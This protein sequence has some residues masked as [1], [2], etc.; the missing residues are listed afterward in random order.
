[1]PVLDLAGRPAD[2]MVAL[3]PDLILMIGAM[4]LLLWAAWRAESQA[5]Q[6][7]VGVACIVLVLVTAG[8]VGY[9]MWR[10]YAAA[11]GPGPIAVDAFR[12][13]SDLIILLG[14]L[15]TIVLSLD[16]NPREGVT[17]PESHVLVLLAS[18]GLMLLCAARAPTL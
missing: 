1:M 12:W 16:Y 13:V 3:G 9:Y 8:A 2:L 18:S 10:G 5:H 7:S 6:R 15:C 14:T 4:L 17:P 11:P